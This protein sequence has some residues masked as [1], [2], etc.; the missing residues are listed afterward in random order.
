MKGTT[1]AL[2][3]PD[4]KDIRTQ[5]AMTP[6]KAAPSRIAMGRE[7]TKRIVAPTASNL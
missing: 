6:P 5:A 3:A 7:V 2:N 1:V 4:P